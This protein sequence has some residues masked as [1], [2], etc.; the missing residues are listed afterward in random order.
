MNDSTAI[1]DLL[2]L[3]NQVRAPLLSVRVSA[4]YNGKKGVLKNAAFEMDR[5]EIL[6]LVGQSGAG[7][8]TI[9]LTILRLLSMKGGAATGEVRF[10]DQELALLPERQM[11]E[12]RGR[13][14]AMVPQSP[15]SSLNPALRIGTQFSE[16]WSAHSTTPYYKWK[17]RLLELL[18]SVSL[19]AEEAFLRRYPRELSV[20]LAQRVLIAMA[21]IHRPALII[22]DEPTSALDIITQSEILQL[23]TTLNRKLKVGILYISHDLLSIAA[24]CHRVAILHQGEIV[25]SGLTGQIFQNPSHPY[26][27]RLISAVPKAG[28][29][30]QVVPERPLFQPLSSD[31]AGG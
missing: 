15:I 17:P 24:I 4:D 26:T 7:K 9:A 6:G 11:R 27:R 1:L 14:I 28:P 13:K 31:F 18:A 12:L 16:A 8:S 3:E 10:E 2:A 19:P 25:E 21:L 22:A 5:G 29:G 23:F 30:I 20:G